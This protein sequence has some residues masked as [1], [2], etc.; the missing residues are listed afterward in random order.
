MKS[1]HW[2]ITELP[3]YKSRDVENLNVLWSTD[4]P[5]SRDAAPALW[6]TLMGF[7]VDA[8]SNYCQRPGHLVV[9]P[10]ELMRSF[11]RNEREPF[12][13]SRVITE[14][15]RRGGIVETSTGPRRRGHA[16]RD[17]RDALR[18]SIRIGRSLCHR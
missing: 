7:F 13:G 16:A 17:V 5:E 11:K 18:E 10:R 2:D 8:I 6:D 12:C 1:E 9:T 4:L 14:L 3:S 15:F